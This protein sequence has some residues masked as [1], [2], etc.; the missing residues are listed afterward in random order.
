MMFRI[1]GEFR[2]VR[3]DAFYGGRH[4]RCV[5]EYL[6]R[7]PDGRWFLHIVNVATLAEPTF[8]E[9]PEEEALGWLIRSRRTEEESSTEERSPVRIAPDWVVP[10]EEAFQYGLTQHVCPPPVGQ[11]VVIKLPRVS[12]AWD[13]IA[14]R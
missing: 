8:T 1:E 11:H 12:R 10:R 5:Y 2:T 3:P 9:I 6:Y 13:A 4:E 7:L 14:R